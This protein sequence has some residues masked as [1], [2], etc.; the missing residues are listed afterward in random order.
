MKLSNRIMLVIFFGFAVMQFNDPDPALWVSVYAV[1]VLVCWTWEKR[2][3]PSALP[4][5]MALVGLV[6]AGAVVTQVESAGMDFWT[7][8]GDGSMTVAG[9]EHLRE[10]GGLCVVTVWM[11]VLGFASRTNSPSETHP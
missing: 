4:W 2:R 10:A 8:L 1:P 5:V 6:S 9:S 7:A 11:T 3:L